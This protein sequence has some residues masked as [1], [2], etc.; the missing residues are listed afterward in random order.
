MSYILYQLLCLRNPQEYY[1]L[2]ANSKIVLIFFNVN[3]DLSYGV[4]YQKLQ[5]ML[6]ASPWFLDHGRVYGR[7]DKNKWFQPNKGIEFTVGS[8]ERHSLGQDIFCLDGSTLIMTPD[9]EK[10]ID[11]LENKEVSVIS[12]DSSGNPIERNGCTVLQTGLVNDIIRITLEDGTELKVTPNH[13]VR[14]ES[15]VY[16]RADS[17]KVGDDLRTVK[18]ER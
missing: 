5:T 6:M 18:Y 7:D 3:L 17:L 12:E 9:G 8:Q 10:R 2:Q 16:T 1:G 14:L 13:L 4:A 11:S 15:G